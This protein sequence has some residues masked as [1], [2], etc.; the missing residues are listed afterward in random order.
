[1]R[2]AQEAGNASEW[3]QQ[4]LKNTINFEGEIELE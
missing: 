4:L 1:M 3:I 2:L